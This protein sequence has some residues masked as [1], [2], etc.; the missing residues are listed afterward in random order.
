MIQTRILVSDDEPLIHRFL[1]PALE[2][3]GY[4]VER[5]DTKKIGL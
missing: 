3:S 5:A 2:A 1:R 4:T